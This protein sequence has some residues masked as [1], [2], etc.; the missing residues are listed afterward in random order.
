M[1]YFLFIELIWHGGPRKFRSD[2]IFDQFCVKKKFI[3][4]R[5]SN[6]DSFI[7]SV[8]LQQFLSIIHITGNL[9]KQV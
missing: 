9:D 5:K 6:M 4:R 3:R 7:I 2:I 8:N 1:I